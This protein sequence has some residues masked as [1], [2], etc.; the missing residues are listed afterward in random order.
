MKTKKTS[1][2]KKSVIAFLTFPLM[3]ITGSV[4]TSCADMLDT[5]SD[6]VGRVEDSK[7]NT[8]EDS[9]NYVTGAIRCMQVI[10]DRT[11][12]LG[13]LRADLMTPSVDAT[14]AIQQMA[15]NDF[16]A[17][18]QYNNISDYYA[19]INNCNYFIENADTTLD[20]LGKKIFEKEYAVMKTYRAW[21]YLQLAKIYGKVPLI[22]KPLLTE[23]DALAATQQKYADINE[24]CSYFIDDLKPYVDTEYPQYGQMGT[25]KFASPKFF[26]PVRVLLGE[27]CLWTGRYEEACGYFYDLMTQKNNY[28][29]TGVE[30]GTWYVTNLDF[31]TASMSYSFTWNSAQSDDLMSFIPMEQN[32]FYGVRSYIQDLFA[33]TETNY[34]RYQAGPSKALFDLSKAQNYCYVDKVSETQKDTVYAPKTGF[35]HSYQAGDL[36]LAS[37]YNKMTINQ[38]E[39]ALYSS[40][41]Q[42]I[43]KMSNSNFIPLYRRQQVYL[44]FAEAL[45]RA[46]Y[47]E[48]A[49]CIL[50]YGLTNKNIEKYVSEEE[51]S[52]ASAYLGFN[53]DIFTENNT[54]GIHARGC[55]DVDCDTTYC[56]PAN[57]SGEEEIKYVEDLIVTEMAL[58]SAFEGKR[59]FDLMRIALRRNDPAYL[60]EPI[61]RRAGAKDEATYSRL[62]DTHN[63]YLPIQ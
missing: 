40:D 26:I 58:E 32:E 37:C 36:R 17:P 49:F 21:T 53:D 46:G 29:Q 18:N 14:T 51:R 62:I 2:F 38:D 9:L 45:N 10:A 59:F 35:V 25:D 23:K 16:S 34:Y 55:G 43:E 50:K 19:V 30:R 24:I 47:P 1:Y 12:L 7:I 27:M 44:M 13:E 31:T 63:W 20:R 15:A 42:Q 60:A 52:K 6:M 57:L 61:S 56:I 39:T 8:P 41:Y 33:S 22:L 3:G 5:K 48:S 11:L 28:L 4:L 54:L